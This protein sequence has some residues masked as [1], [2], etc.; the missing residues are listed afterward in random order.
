MEKEEYG[1][2]IERG[3]IR[4]VT[5]KGCRV[6]SITRSGI[7]TPPLMP[8]FHQHEVEDDKLTAKEP[9]FAVG[10]LVYFFMFPDGDGMIV[11]KCS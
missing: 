4:E 7:T 8:A 11:G 3:K 10:D 5:E 2:V 1:A 6:D 9:A